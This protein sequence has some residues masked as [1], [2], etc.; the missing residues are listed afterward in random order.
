MSLRWL[1]SHGDT[2]VEVLIAIT[3]ISTVLGGAFV[4]ARRNLDTTQQAKER[5]QGVRLI[6]S[7]IE[8]LKVAAADLADTADNIFTRSP[9]YFCLDNSLTPHDLG[10][11]VPPDVNADTFS[12]P[13]YPDE[14]TLDSAN[15]TYNSG[16]SQSIPYYVSVQRDTTDQNLFAIRARWDRAGGD[17]REEAMIVYRVH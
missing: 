1:N 5:D 9:G 16:T 2:I 17:G 14:C 8:R 15:G 3:V 7:Q 4:S 6:E 10:G 12:T 13:Q 11:T